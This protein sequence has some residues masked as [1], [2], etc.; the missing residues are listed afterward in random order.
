[1]NIKRSVCYLG[2][3]ASVVVGSVS[4]FAFSNEHHQH[5]HQEGYESHAS[6]Q[7]GHAQLTFVLE[8]N[9]AE[10]AFA[11]PAANVFGFEHVATTAQE[12]QKIQDVLAGFRSGA[13]FSFN[14]SASCVMNTSEVSN[15]LERGA[16]HS[17]ADLHASYSLLCQHPEALTELTLEFKDLG[18]GI[19]QVSVQWIVNG[20][21]GA[22]KWTPSSASMLLN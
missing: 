2:L 3:S 8:G 21:Q 4:A 1:M 14:E 20:Q 11:S 19:E 12:T 18:A 17:H 6:H 22:G 9:E 10:L 15:E 5:A 7:H 16:S 13:W